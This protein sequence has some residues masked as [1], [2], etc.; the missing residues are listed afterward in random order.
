MNKRTG[1]PSHL[2]PSKN[3]SS[4]QDTKLWLLY[5]HIYIYIY[6]LFLIAKTFF[7]NFF[8]NFLSSFSFFFF[9]SSF[10]LSNSLYPWSLE[11]FYTWGSHWYTEPLQ[12]IFL[13]WY[14]SVE[15]CCLSVLSVSSCLYWY[16]FII[17]LLIC[18]LSFHP[19]F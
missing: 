6:I 13:R 18:L 7:I 4:C 14:Y 17:F 12:N 11:P 8:I 10:L 2:E 3:I 15:V 1:R 16:V 19:I 9:L 5:I